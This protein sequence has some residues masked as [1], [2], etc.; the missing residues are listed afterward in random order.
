MKTF[1]I[2]FLLCFIVNQFGCGTY[3]CHEITPYHYIRIQYKSSITGEN[4]LGRSS[5]TEGIYV[6]KQ[7]SDTANYFHENE[8][9]GIHIES[10]LEP[11]NYDSIYNLTHYLSYNSDMD[12]LETFFKL[13][14]GKCTYKIISQKVLLNGNLEDSDIFRISLYK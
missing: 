5:N 10:E 8:L 14:Q 11:I 12:T 4:L 6:L 2:I 1:T 9:I 7:D 3:E 13:L